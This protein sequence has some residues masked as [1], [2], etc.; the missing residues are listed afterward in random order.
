MA[1]GT[2]FTNLLVAHWLQSRKT[3][4]YDTR[5]RTMGLAK[6]KPACDKAENGYSKK[7]YGNITHSR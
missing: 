7:E 3:Q 5:S 1:A 4:D 2:Q 6:Q